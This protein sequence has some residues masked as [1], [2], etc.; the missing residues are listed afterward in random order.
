MET[1]TLTSPISA[2]I[3]QFELQTRLFNNVLDNV[4]DDHAHKPA[5]ED[6]N[7]L[8]WLTGHVLSSRFMMANVLGMIENEPHADLFGN[9]KGLQKDVKYPSINELRKEWNP[10]NEK[11]IAKLNSLTNEELN[12]KAPFPLPMSGDNIKTAIAFFA[13]HEAYTIGQMGLLRRF[14]G[15]PG[16]KYN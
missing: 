8:A 12:A 15:L 9:G 10:L 5:K 2:L 11:L 1:K 14:H 16:M 3:S 7:H 4:N 13:H 6:T